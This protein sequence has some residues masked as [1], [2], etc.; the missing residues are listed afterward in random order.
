MKPHVFLFPD[1]LNHN[2]MNNLNRIGQH[3]NCVIKIEERKGQET[4]V[5]IRVNGQHDLI[6]GKCK[7]RMAKEAIETA[8][9]DYIQNGTPA[10]SFL[11]HL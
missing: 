10:F 6:K 3:T 5:L 8:L 7:L 1:F 2:E 11:L 9:L 4:H